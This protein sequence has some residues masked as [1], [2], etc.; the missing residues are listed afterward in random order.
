MRG[1][2]FLLPHVK[3]VVARRAPPIDPRSRLAGNKAAVLP[4]ILA[5]RRP[6]R[7]WITVAATRRASR[8]SRGMLA[9]SV[10]PS[11][12]AR[13]TA[14]PSWYRRCAERECGDEVSVAIGA[15]PIRAFNRPIT[16]SIVSPSARAVKVS[17]I[18]CLRIGAASSTTSSMEGASRASSKARARTAS[19]SA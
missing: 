11:P 19:I 7:P 16:A 3:M 14:A 5:R 13:A 1:F 10:R 8:I 12:D 6:C 15:Y 2:P 18:L 4:E 17:A 9:A